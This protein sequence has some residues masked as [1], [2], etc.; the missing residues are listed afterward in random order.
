[1]DVQ[2]IAVPYDSG[3]RS[4]RMGLGPEH[5][6]RRGLEDALRA[7]G[8]DA[9]VSTIEAQESFQA[10]IKTAFEL[11]RR[12][13][14][15]VG[16][17]CSR[18]RF[19]LVLS[20]NCNSSLGT[21][22]GV[23]HTPQT[24]IIWLDSHG[25]FNTPETTT[26]GFLDGMGFAT[27]VGLC[28]KEMAASIPNFQPVHGSH[29]MHIG[30][31]D[32]SSDEEELFRQAG[33]TVICAETIRRLGVQDALCSSIEALSARVQRVYLHIDL[34]VLDPALTKANE[35][36]APDGLLPAQVEEIIQT[37]GERFQIC[38]S[39]IASYDPKCD[40]HDQTLRAGIRLMETILAYARV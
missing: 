7:K 37:I 24:G 6:L 25:D 36:A 26:S 13:S 21:L 34:D 11:H 32:F 27:A 23:G 12:L 40:E 31:R 35:F 30:V 28:W 20:G 19:P 4:Q 5:F 16:E 22:A 8:H 39:A 10:E 1:M 18:Q 29:A 3:H 15:S 14:E 9:R 2:I 38:A 33:V 17:A